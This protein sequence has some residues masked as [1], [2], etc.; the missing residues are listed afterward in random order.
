M[1]VPMSEDLF[2]SKNAFYAQYTWL[3]R[4]TAA[5]SDLGEIVG[6]VKYTGT[7]PVVLDGKEVPGMVGITY[8]A[9][10]IPKEDPDA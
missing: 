2:Y 8:E 7:R 1:I 6:Q 3:E 9:R 10:I 4:A 5:L